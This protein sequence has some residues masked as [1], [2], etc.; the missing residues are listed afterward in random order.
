MDDVIRFTDEFYILATAST[1]DEGRVL[2]QGDSFAIFD[3]YGDIHQS[4]LGEQGIYHDGTRH[5]SRLEF[6][7]GNLRPFLLSS[8][9]NEDNILFT[10]DLT[11]PDAY[12][13][14]TIALRRGDLH[15]L[16]SKFLWQ[17]VCYERLQIVN[18]S[19]FPIQVSFGFQFDCDFA[20][21]F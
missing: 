15:I 14:G 3:R 20:D 10:A 19:L 11:N 13:N 1:A 21:I 5:L 2:K 8:M 12:A 16:R 6:R 9:I 17:A 7:L 18:Y 4:G